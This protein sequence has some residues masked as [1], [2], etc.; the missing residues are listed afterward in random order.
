MITYSHKRAR[1]LVAALLSSAPCALL[2]T[3]A[4]AQ[5]NTVP[6]APASP[7]PAGNQSPSSLPQTPVTTDD[8]VAAGEATPTDTA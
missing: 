3:G 2:A 7:A 4:A 5:T 8:A 1:L 6:A